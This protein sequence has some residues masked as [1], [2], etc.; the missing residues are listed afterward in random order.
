[1]KKVTNTWRFIKNTGNI[2][3]IYIQ[4]PYVHVHSLVIWLIIFSVALHATGIDV[5]NIWHETHTNAGYLY[6]SHILHR[7]INLKMTR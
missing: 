4:L 2:V 1:M 7:V 6:H 5:R 3:C